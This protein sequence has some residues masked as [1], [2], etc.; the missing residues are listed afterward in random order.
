MRSDWVI[1]LPMWLSFG[2]T[3]L[4]VIISILLARLAYG[5]VLFVFTALLTAGIM[6]FAAHHLLEIFGFHAE[7][8]SVGGEALSSALFLAAA[9][10]L[11][12]RVRKI[13]YGR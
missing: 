2:L 13:I 6:V 8:L 9:I 11:G 10:Y 1:H 4:G 7:L 5:S 12:Y 3:I